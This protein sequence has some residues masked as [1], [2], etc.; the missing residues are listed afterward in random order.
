VI[1]KPIKK[2]EQSQDLILYK[3]DQI[4]DDMTEMT[5]AMNDVQSHILYMRTL[6]KIGKAVGGAVLK[7]GTSGAVLVLVVKVVQKW[8]EV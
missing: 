3:L 2:V 5:V 7:V 4:K 1:E 6:G 8:L